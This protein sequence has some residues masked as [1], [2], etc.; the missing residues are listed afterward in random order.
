M[1]RCQ[2]GFRLRVEGLGFVRSRLVDEVRHRRRGLGIVLLVLERVAEAV[3][4]MTPIKSHIQP[5]NSPIY[6]PIKPMYTSTTDPY[7]LL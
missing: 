1:S 4:T 3:I 2:F 7:I 5:Y 6:T